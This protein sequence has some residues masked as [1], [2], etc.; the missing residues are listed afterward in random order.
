MPDN[1]YTVPE[2]VQH[3]RHIIQ[4]IETKMGYSLYL[5][6]DCEQ[7]ITLQAKEDVGALLVKNKMPNAIFA[8]NQ[9]HISAA[10]YA[11]I[12]EEREKVPLSQNSR[13]YVVETLTALIEKL[14]KH[15]RG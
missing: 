12:E 3:L 2:Y 13:R 6:S 14:E 4:L 9:P 15:G 1:C 10:F 7:G 5:I 11:H 8:F